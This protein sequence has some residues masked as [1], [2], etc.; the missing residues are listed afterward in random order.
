M[1]PIGTQ[2]QNILGIDE[3]EVVWMAHVALS[4][5]LGGYPK[6]SRPVGHRL[7]SNSA[8]QQFAVGPEI[9]TPAVASAR[10]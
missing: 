6:V 4:R 7:H 2:E 10:P 9:S 1:L 5:G 3:K 8:C